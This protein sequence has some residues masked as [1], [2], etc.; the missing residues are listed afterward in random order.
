LEFLQVCEKIPLMKKL[1][2]FFFAAV[3]AAGCCSTQTIAVHISE[4]RAAVPVHFVTLM[5]KAPPGSI[6]IANL[7]ASAANTPGGAQ[8]AQADL[9]KS[10]A[11]VGA[12]VLVVDKW[13][14]GDYFWE[15]NLTGNFRIEGHAYFAP[16]VNE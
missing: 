6:L 7:F 2:L 9:K 10:A 13:N 11:A 3:L 5:E 15:W 1:T 12:N 16:P 14:E 4:P 8:A